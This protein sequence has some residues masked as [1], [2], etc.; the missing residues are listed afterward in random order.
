MKI[1]TITPI[2]LLLLMQS[3]CYGMD[4]N[5]ITIHNIKDL[6]KI[7]TLQLL[8]FKKL[9]VKFPKPIQC[10]IIDEANSTKL[11]KCSIVIPNASNTNTLSE[12]QKTLSLSFDEVQMDCHGT[13][14][15]K[16][17]N[18]TFTLC[19]NQTIKKHQKGRHLTFNVNLSYEN[20]D[21]LIFLLPENCKDTYSS[22]KSITSIL[23]NSK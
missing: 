13:G 1:N 7:V 9:S 16:E 19:N 23:K 2:A 15:E 5:Q 18:S 11:V 21:T 14:E 12:I 20:W 3:Y 10:M 8:T 22:Y 17:E 6:K 4:Q